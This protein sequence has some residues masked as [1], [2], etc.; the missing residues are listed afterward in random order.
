MLIE[1]TTIA[2]QLNSF[3]LT[4]VER[5]Q[6]TNSRLYRNQRVEMNDIA[7]KTAVAVHPLMKSDRELAS[8]MSDMNLG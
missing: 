5:E 3:R 4:F 1:T 2:R 6:V 7:A 8:A